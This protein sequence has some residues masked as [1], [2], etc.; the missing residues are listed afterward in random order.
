[1]STSNLETALSQFDKIDANLK[2]LE[3]LWDQIYKLI[4]SEINFSVNPEYDD[5]CRAFRSIQK[6]MPRIGDLTLN[7]N[8]YTLDEIAQF[9]LDY[10]EL[11]DPTADISFE[12]S[13]AEP[14]SI[15]SQYRF[16]FNQKR[17]SLVLDAIDQV[18][19][20][21]E[22][23]LQSISSD[24]SEN[25]NPKDSLSGS[26]WTKLRD[27]FQ[28]LDTLLGSSIN[29]PSRW[30]D[31]QRHLR[32]GQVH[33]YNDIINLDWPDIKSTLQYSMCTKYDPVPVEV[34]DLDA[35]VKSKPTGTVSTKLNWNNLNEEEFE[36]LIFQ[37]ISE[38]EGYENSSWLTHTN[39]PD[40]GRDLSVYR[41]I[42]DP[43]S[44]TER[45][46]VIIQCRN[47]LKNSISPREVSILKEQMKLWEPPPVD[48]HIIAT[49]GRFT[50]PA[51]EL[52]EKSNLADT[53]LIIEMWPNSH[54]ERLLASRPHIIGAFGLRD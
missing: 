43:L 36:R 52:V 13:I 5:K 30:S 31:M 1:M 3:N 39:A 11:N 16:D 7:I 34:D 54:L 48:V 50:T 15:L 6:V 17:R 21:I 20:D 18:I 33:D 22:N 25:D 41:V 44:G 28:E 51:V 19:A 38:T 4:P 24:I 45:K 9:R 8:F 2:K 46:R 53:K 10:S 47:T 40:K 23:H 49:S 37:L 35:L 12:N 27:S 42:K 26:K 14:R 32:F 29:R